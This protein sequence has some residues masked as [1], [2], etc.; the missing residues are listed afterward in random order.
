MPDR[1][2]TRYGCRFAVAAIALAATI[3]GAAGAELIYRPINPAFGGS[4]LIDDFL[5][6]T[7][8][9]QSTFQPSAPLPTDDDD[10]VIDGGGGSGDLDDDDDEMAVGTMRVPMGMSQQATGAALEQLNR[11]AARR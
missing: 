9:I 2:A 6:G 4:P 10:P 3:P 11:G 1:T 5:V 8:Q 7:A